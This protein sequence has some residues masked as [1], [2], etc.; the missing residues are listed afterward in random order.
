M[1]R[2]ASVKC[3]GVGFLAGLLIVGAAGRALANSACSTRVSYGNSAPCTNNENDTGWVG[4]DQLS[5]DTEYGVL[6]G[7]RFDTTSSAWDTNGDALNCD[8]GPFADGQTHT[9]SC[10][11]HIGFYQCCIQNLG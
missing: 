1:A 11:T 10:G 8:I 5:D 9:R 3:L 4:Y 7:S 2:N 6:A